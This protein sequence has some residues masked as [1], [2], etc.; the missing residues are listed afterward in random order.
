MKCEKCFPSVFFKLLNCCRSNT[1]HT[2]SVELWV[3]PGRSRGDDVIVASGLLFLKVLSEPSHLVGSIR[4][5]PAGDNNM[6]AQLSPSDKQYIGQCFPEEKTE[7]QNSCHDMFVGI[8]CL[9]KQVWLTKAIYTQ[10]FTLPLKQ[11][12]NT[13]CFLRTGGITM[14][15]ERFRDLAKAADECR[16]V[17]TKRNQPTSFWT[18]PANNFYRRSSVDPNSKLQTLLCLS[19]WSFL[20]HSSHGLVS[21]SPPP[22]SMCLTLA[23]FALTE[24]IWNKARPKPRKPSVFWALSYSRK[25]LCLSYLLKEETKQSCALNKHTDTSLTHL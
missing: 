2:C 21:W 15:L 10:H 11:N 24:H 19:T 4:P 23:V 8:F 13:P 25:P 9:F 17:K 6:T 14:S 3:Y 1:L 20:A 7:D 12:N 5:H 22:S 18:S 16:I